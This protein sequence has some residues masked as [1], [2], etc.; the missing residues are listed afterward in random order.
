MCNNPAAFID[1][2]GARGIIF[3]LIVAPAVN[4]SVAGIK[5]IAGLK[6]PDIGV[7]RSSVEFIAPDDVPLRGR[8]SRAAGFDRRVRSSK[9]I[10][11][12]ALSLVLAQT[13]FDT[14]HMPCLPVPPD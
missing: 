11:A 4:V 12:F 9:Y 13:Q 2:I 1:V 3:Q 6:C 5:S 8:R 10:E 14:A 7:D